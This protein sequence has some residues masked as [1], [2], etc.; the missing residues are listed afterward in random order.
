MK[1]PTLI[2]THQI[3][4]TVIIIEC[5]AIVQKMLKPNKILTKILLPCFHVPFWLSHILVYC[6]DRKGHEHSIY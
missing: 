4:K 6:L 5:C 1:Y 3:M 2:E